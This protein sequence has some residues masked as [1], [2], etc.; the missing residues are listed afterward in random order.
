[1][2]LLVIVQVAVWP[3]PTVTDWPTWRVPPTQT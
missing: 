1:M 3:M 2:S